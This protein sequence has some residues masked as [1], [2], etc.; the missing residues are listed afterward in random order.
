VKSVT[1]AYTQKQIGILALLKPGGD[2]M[3]I[4]WKETVLTGTGFNVFL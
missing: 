1:T 4:N 2:V 3:P